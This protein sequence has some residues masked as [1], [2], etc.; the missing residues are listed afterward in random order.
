MQQ[1][2]GTLI[3]NP[4]KKGL[5]FSISAILGTVA[6]VALLFSTTGEA[7]AQQDFSKV[8]IKTIPVG[9]AVSML[10]GAGGNIGV[11][12]GPDGV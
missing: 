4:H 1:L 12:S 8:Q 6:A 7:Q 10:M 2:N 3:Y 5:R 9:G 11:I